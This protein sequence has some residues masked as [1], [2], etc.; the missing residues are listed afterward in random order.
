MLLWRSLLRC[1]AIRS[2]RRGGEGRAMA[3]CRDKLLQIV[4]QNRRSVAMVNPNRRMVIKLGLASAGGALLVGRGR[5]ARADDGSDNVVP[6]SPISVPFSTDLP[7]ST[8]KQPRYDLTDPAHPR[9]TPLS[10]PPAGYTWTHGT[11]E[12]TPHKLWSNA[13]GTVGAG[14]FG[15]YPPQK[16]YELHVRQATHNFSPGTTG[17]G[18][19]TIWGFDGISPGPLFHERYGVP[20]LVRFYNELPRNDPRNPFP[21]GSP[22]ITTHLHNGHTPTESDGHPLDF[23]PSKAAASAAALK[24]GFAG[25]KD[26]HYPNVYAG[27][28]TTPRDPK[29]PADGDPNEALASLWYHDHRVD[30]TAAN[31][32]HGL[33][34]FYNL[35][36][37]L[38]TGDENTGLRLPSGPYD[39]P[40]MFF[41]PAFDPEYQGVF[42][43]FNTDGVLGDKFTA[44]GIIQ[45]K[46]AVKQRRYRL[47]LLNIGPARWY[48]FWVAD[49][50]GKFIAKPFW[51]ISS[52]GNLL[53]FPLLVDSVRISVAERPDIVIDFGD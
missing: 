13:D 44:N 17:W 9:G 50:K 7:I 31:V 2:S 42:D 24:A 49:S 22:E 33:A 8:V 29:A 37:H 40:I 21:F 5:R 10:P 12:R 46:F 36:D 52:D 6:P 47:R 25:Y 41:D 11:L 48:E 43:V 1:L 18:D 32:V 19:S 15:N 34:G 28:S 45:P 38:D 3:S 4:Q 16:F 30:F 20:I 14:A 51:Q 53:P 27:F 23:F 35:F 26:Q 39:V